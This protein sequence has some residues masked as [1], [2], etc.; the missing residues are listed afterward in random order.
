MPKLGENAV[1]NFKESLNG[2]STCTIVIK[3]KME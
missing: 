1:F 3:G 2:E